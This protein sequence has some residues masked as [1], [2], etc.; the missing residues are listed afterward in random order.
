MPIPIRPTRDSQEGSLGSVF[1]DPISLTPM[2]DAQRIILEQSNHLTTTSAKKEVCSKTKDFLFTMWRDRDEN[3]ILAQKTLN[4]EPTFKIPSEATSYDIYQMVQDGVLV[5]KGEHLA[6]LTDYGKKVL[7]KIIMDQE[8]EFSKNRKKEKFVFS[9]TMAIDQIDSEGIKQDQESMEEQQQ[10]LG[11]EIQK[12]YDLYEKGLGRKEELEQRQEDLGTVEDIIGKFNNVFTPEEPPEDP[13]LIN[14][15]NQTMSGEKISSKKKFTK[16]YS[17]IDELI[18]F[19][20]L[21]DGGKIEK[22][23]VEFKKILDD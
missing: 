17:K 10:E 22:F 6:N 2:S 7:G 21:K 19:D 11:P 13:N 8:N 12:F 20:A 16:I 14:E 23:S 15:F 4:G 18:E 3:I 5:H 9:Q 1:S